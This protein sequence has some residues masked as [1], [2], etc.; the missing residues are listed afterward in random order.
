MTIVMRTDRPVTRSNVEVLAGAAPARI[1]P[2]TPA[3]APEMANTAILVAFTL[4]PH[5]ATA[6]GPSFTAMS[7]SPNVLR[8]S[9]T[10]AS[11]SRANTT[12]E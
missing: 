2:P 8:R 10:T 5:E 6:A 3:M 7:R 1:A 4:M 9:A 11:I 12:A